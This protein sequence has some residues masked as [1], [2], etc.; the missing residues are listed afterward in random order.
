MR[1]CVS[2]AHQRQIQIFIILL[3]LV[4]NKI[5]LMNDLWSILAKRWINLFRFFDYFIIFVENVLQ[6]IRHLSKSLILMFWKQAKNCVL[7]YCGHTHL[8]TMLFQTVQNFWKISNH[9]FLKNFESQIFRKY[10]VNM[11]LI[12]SEKWITLINLGVKDVSSRVNE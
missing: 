2:A 6:E 7:D 10:L 5:C 4:R 1:I 8:L 9:K 11:K 3:V 12:K